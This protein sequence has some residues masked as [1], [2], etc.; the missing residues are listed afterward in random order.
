M[1]FVVMPV[2]AA[3][4][5]LALLAVPAPAEQRPSTTAFICAEANR[6]VAAQRG[7][8]L[9]TG[10]YTYDRF[11]SDASACSPE[12]TTEAAFAPTRDNPQC[13][14]GYRCRDRIGRGGG[15]SN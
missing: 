4:L 6:L 9:G 2:V 14:I 1:R 12:Q 7:I 11:A 13:F 8:V 5:A 15:G 3:V 10:P